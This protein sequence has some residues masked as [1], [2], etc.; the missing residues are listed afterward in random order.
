MSRFTDPLEIGGKYDRKVL[1]K[2]WGLRGFQAI[3]RGVYTPQK[4]GLIFL[5]VTREREGW[6]TP[7]NNFIEGDLLFWDGER[8]HGSDSRITSAVK[9]GEEIHVFFRD[10]RLTPFVYCGKALAVRSRLM[11]ERPSEFVFQLLDVER[12]HESA[13]SSNLEE[14]SADY[15]VLSA[16]GYKNINREVKIKSRGVA[17]GVFRG[18]LL[19][20]WQGSCAVTQVQEPRVLRS[21]HIKPWSLSNVE[22]KVDHFNGLLLVANLDALFNVGLISFRESGKILISSGLCEKDQRRMSLTA[23]LQLRAIHSDS[24]KYLEFHRDTQFENAA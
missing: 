6:M 10:R 14:E 5:F 11:L 16:A 21:S 2:I 7:Y 19:R 8:G 9:N 13:M 12:G 22:E 18:N 24:A 20:L 3:G 1:A 15:A 4:S 23:D 17:Q